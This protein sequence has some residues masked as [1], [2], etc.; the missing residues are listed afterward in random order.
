MSYFKAD[1]HRFPPQGWEGSS[2]DLFAQ[3]QGGSVAE[4][5][6]NQIRRPQHKADTHSNHCHQCHM[7]GTKEPDS[8]ILS[9]MVSNF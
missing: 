2:L 1:R 6:Q 7:N 3:A 4:R 8:F 5:V 9:T